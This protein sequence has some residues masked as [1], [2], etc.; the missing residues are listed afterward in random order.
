MGCNVCFVVINTCVLSATRF[1]LGFYL[2]HKFS[3]FTPQRWFLVFVFACFFVCLEFQIIRFVINT[4]TPIFF[5][6]CFTP[7]PFLFVLLLSTLVCY[8]PIELILGFFCFINFPI[9]LSPPPPQIHS[10]VPY[11]MVWV[12]VV[13]IGVIIS[14][15]DAHFSPSPYK[16]GGAIVS[17]YGILHIIWRYT[18]ITR[19]GGR[20]VIDSPY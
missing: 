4:L 17:L 11:F 6:L 8:Q 14:G 15:L 5:I 2:F 20:G 13:L 12:V 10:Q 3:N 19:F 16:V 9:L 1:D 7:P 18:C